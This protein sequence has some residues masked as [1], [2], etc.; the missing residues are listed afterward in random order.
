MS[1]DDED[2]RAKLIE[3]VLSEMEGL[4]ALVSGVLSAG[5]AVRIAGIAVWSAAIAGAIVNDEPL[6]SALAVMALLAFSLVDAYHGHLYAS[7]LDE[8]IRDERIVNRYYEALGRYG[9]DERRLKRLDERL[10]NRRFGVH[11]KL[12]RPEIVGPEGHPRSWRESLREYSGVLGLLRF[13]LQSRPTVVFRGL[14]PVL[15]IL[16]VAT[17]AVLA[18]A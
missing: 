15:A 2:R 13:V 16:G 5:N 10:A 11:S 1:R 8:L 9:G 17:T 18:I 6:L 7:I 4:R 3:L 12:R 14:Y